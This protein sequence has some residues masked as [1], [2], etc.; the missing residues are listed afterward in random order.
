MSRTSAV[1]GVVC[2]VGLLSAMVY[3]MALTPNPSSSG[4]S[5]VTV[6]GTSVS[7]TILD[8]DAE[9]AQGLSNHPGLRPDEG[10]LFIFPQDGQYSFWMKDMLFSIDILW[11]TAAG[12]IIT[13]APGV[14]PET[15]PR[16]FTSDS[17]ARYVL[18]VPAGFVEAHGIKVGDT[19]SF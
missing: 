18:E 13:I 6:G 9:R 1:L 5:V 10:M 12:E 15:F 11:I 7:V 14:S 16:A 4:N 17:P 2:I 19:V 3:T 8:T